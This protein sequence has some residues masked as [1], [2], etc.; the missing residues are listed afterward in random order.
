MLLVLVPVPGAPLCGILSGPATQLAPPPSTQPH[1]AVLYADYGF[2]FAISEAQTRAILEAAE[3]K[4]PEGRDVWF[5]LV[6]ANRPRLLHEAQFRAMVYYSPDHS[7]AEL[8]R[9]RCL[10]L[11]LEREPH[12]GEYVQVAPAGAHFG[13][14][15]AVPNL[16]DLPF[17]PLA[18]D[19]QG[20]PI[21][22]PDDELV[23]LV[24]F[25]RRAEAIR[26]GGISLSPAASRKQ[27]IVDIEV[28]G[29]DYDVRT[30]WVVAMLDGR[31]Y[32]LR[33]EKDKGGYR[34]LDVA[35]WRS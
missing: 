16:A 11:S 15:P 28:S 27:P 14:S 8:R 19:R 32:S 31:G 3:K 24:R 13:T 9:G 5:V 25:A 22:L 29:S 34:L 2:P 7:S 1:V 6:I 33:I 23:R 35:L 10:Y 17:S 20:K 12:A 26:K 21:R 4:R 30:G 18:R